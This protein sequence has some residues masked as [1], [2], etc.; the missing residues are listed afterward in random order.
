MKISMIVRICLLVFCLG[1]TSKKQPEESIQTR[2]YR[3][4]DQGQVEQAIILLSEE[5]ES[6]DKSHQPK[7]DHSEE[8]DSLRVTLASAYFKLS[9]LEMKDIL[10]SVV[11]GNRVNQL[12]PPILSKNPD[13]DPK[14]GEGLDLIFRQIFEFYKSIQWFSVL[15]A[16]GDE[17]IEFLKHA[18][19]ILNTVQSKK[20]EDLI[21]KAIIKVVILNSSLTSPRVGLAAPHMIKENGKCVA[22]IEN[23]KTHLIGFSEDVLS[24]LT[25]LIQAI[26]E[27]KDEFAANVEITKKARS[28]IQAAKNEDFQIESIADAISLTAILSQVGGTLDFENCS[29]NYRAK[30]D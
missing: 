8:T 20:P 1:C 28:A 13:I 24:I 11:E 27:R 29:I 10:K 26:P 7:G 15:P 19:K 4:I 17:K 21:F 6:R 30:T 22:Q 3:L 2:A 9:G 14:V 25:D 23:M 5:I 18:T 12:K 16:V